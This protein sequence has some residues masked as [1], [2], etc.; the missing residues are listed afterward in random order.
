MITN[1]ALPII[2]RMLFEHFF[3]VATTLD[4]R[5]TLLAFG[6]ISLGGIFYALQGE[7]IK[8]LLFETIYAESRFHSYILINFALKS[9]GNLKFLSCSLQICPYRSFIP[10]LLLVLL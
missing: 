6:F 5:A 8:R 2:L 4:F 9:K 1:I 10:L 7:V 3:V